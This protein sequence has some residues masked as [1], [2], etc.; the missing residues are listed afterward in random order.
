MNK[1]L[2]ANRGEIALR[3]IKTC[4]RLGIKTVTI[5]AG[6][7]SFLP[8]ASAADENISLGFG[9]LKDTYLNQEKIIQIAKD[10]NVDGIHPGYGFLSENTE[11][12]KKV[13]EAGIKFIGPSVEAIELMGDKKESKV[14]M[15]ELGIPLV[16][17]Y[18]GESQDEA[19]LLEEAKKI[20]FPVLIKATAGGGGKGM[21]IVKAE[22]DFS[23]ALASSKREALNAFSNDKVLIE[24]YIEE[25]RHIE[26]QIVSD[27]QGNHFHFYE[28]E[29]SIQRRYQK[30]IEETPSVA[31]DEKLRKEM[32][33]TAVKIAEGIHY[34]GAGTIEYILAP[35][36]SFYFLEMN[37]RL[38]VEHPITELVTGVD[39][40]ELQIKA[41]KGEAFDFAQVDVTQK[42]HAVECRIYA[43]DPDNEFLP[44]IGRIQQVCGE[45]NFDFR[46]DC[47]Y[48]DGNNIS[49][50]YDPML[51]KLIVHDDDRFLATEKMQS[52][53]NL[54]LFAGSK[55]NRDFL[56]RILANDLYHEG[57]IHTH[58][59]EQN[60]EDLKA[61]VLSDDQLA[62]FAASA[63]ISAK[64]EEKNCWDYLQTGFKKTLVI[65]GEEIIVQINDFL[66]KGISFKFNHQEYV[67]GT[68]Y[69][70]ANQVFLERNNDVFQCFDFPF[71]VKKRH[72]FINDLEAIVEIKP[73]V[74]RSS[75]ALNLTEG[76]LQSPMPGKIFKILTGKGKVV[77]KGD[78]VLIVEAMK[79][80]HTIKATKDGEIKDIF[81]QEGD[82]VQGGV[83]LCEIE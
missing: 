81:Y 44:T 67:F 63:L 34:E 13:T 69:T 6:N 5:F 37:T 1:V 23:D 38:Q 18:H 35:D 41:A 40:V 48:V 10:L 72:M 20:G 57:K 22:E 43:E 83:L 56:K 55:T 30:V 54:T 58:F 66:K 78:P 25:P 28:R 36:K 45:K 32:C 60:G 2:I 14:K 64:R 80:E 76:S 82:Q 16:P 27:G 26:V 65:N 47:G 53:L 75:D 73:K 33:E 61:R 49:T 4:K 7:D 39:L 59:L 24:K 79:M 11:F 42:G 52:A 29:C 12:C 8:H 74:A 21:R 3:V 70:E 15:G 17:G 71:Q 50:S 19:F 31:L 9:E 62:T 68:I 51:A 46:L 77:K